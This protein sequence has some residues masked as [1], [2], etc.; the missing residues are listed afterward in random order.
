MVDED[1]ATL[2]ALASGEAANPN[3]PGRP[4]KWG[5]VNQDPLQTRELRRKVR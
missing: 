1:L 2:F 5:N 3:L 4:P